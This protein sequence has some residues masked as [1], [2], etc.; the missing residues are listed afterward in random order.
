M[1]R[2]EWVVGALAGV[3]LLALAGARAEA[4]KVYELPGVKVGVSYDLPL[5]VRGGLAPHKWRVVGGEL[6]PQLTLEE[7]GRLHGIATRARR[8][9]YVF[10]VGVTDSSEPPKT[11]E[12]ALKLLVEAAEMEFVP[13]AGA[14]QT[15]EF[16]PPGGGKKNSE[17]KTTEKKPE[18]S[19]DPPPAEP[20][21]NPKGKA[22]E[23]D[24]AKKACEA[25]S[26]QDSESEK[27][28]SVRSRPLRQGT[29]T[30]SG[31]VPAKTSGIKVRVNEKEVPTD[32]STIENTDYQVELSAAL[33]KGQ[34]VQVVSADNPS[35]VSQKVQVEPPLLDDRDTVEVSVYVGTAIDSFAGEE[36]NQLLNPEIS[37][38]IK[39]RGVAGFNFAARLFGESQ[40]KPEAKDGANQ[41][42]KWRD[43]QL[44]VYGETVHGARSTDIDCKKNSSFPSCDALVPDATQLQEPAF[45]LLRNATSLE[46]F[47]GLRWEFAQLQRNALPLSLYLKGQTGFITAVNG[48]DDAA[49]SHHGAL[50]LVVTK[51]RLT[52]SYLEGGFGKSDLFAFRPNDRW[53]FDG[54]VNYALNE[55][56]TFFGQMTV[57][58]DFGGGPDSIQ[59][60]FGL[61]FDIPELLRK[62]KKNGD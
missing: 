39:A 4:E 61:D 47:A 49:G 11:L 29:A 53:K 55:V 14:T 15:M 5:E 45:F 26:A 60:Y 46:G 59:S 33:L 35:V 3:L 43:Q 31:K 13:P 28:I 56:V 52:G 6:P 16:N 24:T 40:E 38:D 25:G 57:D 18:E 36:A 12:F 1:R 10:R 34:T 20:E 2:A 62:A 48:P 8:E 9:P 37:G 7:T 23:G 42:W 41:S 44:W 21:R 22:A 54:Q 58:S 30:L 27:C 17:S 19:E 32:R 50:G 51:G